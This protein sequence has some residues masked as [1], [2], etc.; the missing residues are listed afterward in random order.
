MVGVGDVGV[1][2]GFVIVWWCVGW[3]F[4]C[5]FVWFVWVLVYCV[6]VGM[7]CCGLFV[8]LY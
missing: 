5:V 1:G 2:G 4:V 3:L 8:D 7:F 6:V